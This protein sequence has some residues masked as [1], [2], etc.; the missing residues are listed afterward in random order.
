MLL[1][2]VQQ[3]IQF[4]LVKDLGGGFKYLFSFSPTWGKILI[5]TNIYFKG[6]G[7][8]YQ[9]EIDTPKKSTTTLLI[10]ENCLIFHN[11]LPPKKKTSW[12]GGGR[13]GGGYHLPT[14]FAQI[15]F[16]DSIIN[17]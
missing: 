7:K 17:S 10:A 2:V 13:G 5:L 6:V 16:V 15:F 8:N 9:P 4:I 12:K 11:H 3:L 1:Y 14:F